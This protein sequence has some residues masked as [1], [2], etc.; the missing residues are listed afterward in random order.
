MTV[1]LPPF[2]AVNNENQIQ[3]EYEISIHIHKRYK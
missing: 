3:Y 1:A 2:A